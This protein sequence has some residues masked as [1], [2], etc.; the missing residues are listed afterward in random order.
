M[1]A[2]PGWS[3]A[4]LCKDGW[5]FR[6]SAEALDGFHQRNREDRH[7]NVMVQLFKSL[8]RPGFLS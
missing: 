3:F 6:H 8:R 7:G 4:L 5:E 2:S 1:E